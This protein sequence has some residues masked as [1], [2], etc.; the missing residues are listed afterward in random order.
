MEIVDAIAYLARRADDERRLFALSKSPA[1]DFARAKTEKA[2]KK[3][4]E[5][6]GNLAARGAR[7]TADTPSSGCPKAG[8][9]AS[10]YMSFAQKRT[11]CACPTF[12]DV[13][14]DSATSRYIREAGNM[15]R[16]DNSAEA[17]KNHA[18]QQREYGK[19]C[20]ATTCRPSRCP[21]RH[22]FCSLSAQATKTSRRRQNALK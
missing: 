12:A 2:F 8:E 17:E 16:L 7:N 19:P 4:G 14:V 3:L 9:L 21:L 15:E 20:R 10:F 18:R 5:Q 22:I 11:L 1:A 13:A 6:D